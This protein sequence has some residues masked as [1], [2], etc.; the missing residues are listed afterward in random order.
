MNFFALFGSV[1]FT[2]RAS[3]GMIFLI[4]CGIALLAGWSFGLGVAGPMSVLFFI[5]VA[6]LIYI[7][8]WNKN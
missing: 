1:I 4:Y 2:W 8:K 3:I 5:G 7:N 6:G